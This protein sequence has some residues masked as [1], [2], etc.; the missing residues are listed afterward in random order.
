MEGEESGWFSQLRDFVFKL[1]RSEKNRT[2][3]YKLC[4]L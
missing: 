1:I 2:I 3:N 4:G